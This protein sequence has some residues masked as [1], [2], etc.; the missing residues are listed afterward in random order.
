MDPC[1]LA[2]LVSAFAIAIAKNTTN[3]DELVQISIMFDYLSDTLD[4][5]IA[6][7]VLIKRQE[8]R[9]KEEKEEEKK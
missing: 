7:R 3:D 5:I 1:E 2:A 9:D 6:Q 8:L 4:A